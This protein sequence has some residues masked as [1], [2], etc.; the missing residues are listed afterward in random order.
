MYLIELTIFN[1]GNIK[2]KYGEN[3]IHFEA[4]V[5]EI[6]EIKRLAECNHLLYS[7][8]SIG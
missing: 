8:A 4:L 7:L 5:E 2:R 6:E 1:T 3:K